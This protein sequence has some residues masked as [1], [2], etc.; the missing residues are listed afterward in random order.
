MNSFISNQLVLQQGIDLLHTISEEDFVA[1]HPFCFNSSIGAHF[2][3]NIEHYQLFLKGLADQQINYDLRIRDQR[4]ETDLAYCI[5]TMQI[6]KQQLN[7]L[8][9][10]ATDQLI[11]MVSPSISKEKKIQTSIERELQFLLSHSIH[12]YAIIATICYQSNVAL[13]KHFGVAPSTIDHQ[14]TACAR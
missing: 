9:S 14:K 10:Q 7:D 3:H 5:E 4:I 11:S 2:R 1:T 13:P 6:I 12:H 8:C